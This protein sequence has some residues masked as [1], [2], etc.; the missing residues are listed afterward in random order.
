MSELVKAKVNS[1]INTVMLKTDVESGGI[2]SVAVATPP[3]SKHAQQPTTTP[4]GDPT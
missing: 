2:A 3:R 1:W 4:T